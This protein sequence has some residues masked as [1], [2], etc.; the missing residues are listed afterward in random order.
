MGWLAAAMVAALVVSALIYRSWLKQRS[1]LIPVDNVR[2]YTVTMI[3]D[4][5][6]TGEVICSA[7]MPPI[8]SSLAYSDD[9]AMVQ[10]KVSATS[11]AKAAGYV[12]RQ[13]ARHGINPV[14]VEAR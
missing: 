6:D 4:R 13:L 2:R 8:I 12:R 9:H 5:L 14:R 7:W 3:L 1:T 11:S 10:I